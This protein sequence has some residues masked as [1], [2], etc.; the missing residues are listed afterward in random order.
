MTIVPRGRALGV[1]Q[2]IPFEDRMSISQKELEHQ[3]VVLLGGRSAEQL[4][5]QETTAGAENDLERAT[6]IARRMVTHW[7]M[8]PKLGPVSYKTSEEDPFLGREMHRQRQF[9]EHT[10]EIIDAEVARIL[11]VAAESSNE[12]LRKFQPELER[13][14]RALLEREELSEADIAELIGPSVHHRNATTRDRIK[15]GTVM[16]PQDAPGM[17]SETTSPVANPQSPT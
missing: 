13:L 4:I 15:P 3:L 9:S 2:M 6:M 7:G 10:Q 1:T 12:L 17:T 14:T 5:Y 11:H 16:S 8:S